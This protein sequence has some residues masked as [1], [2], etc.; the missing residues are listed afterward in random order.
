MI[1]TFVEELSS[2]ETQ[3]EETTAA[4]SRLIEELSVDSIGRWNRLI[5][6]TNWEKGEVIHRWRTQLKG[7]NL[8]NSSYSDESWSR[9]VGNVSPQHVGRLRR[10]FERFGASREQYPALYWS[11]FQAAL[12]WDDAEMW[13]EGANLDQWSVANMIIKRSVTLGAPADMKPDDRDIILS[14]LDEDASPF[15]D[16][17]AILEGSVSRI[18]PAERNQRVSGDTDLEAIPFDPQDFQEDK[19]NKKGKKSAETDHAETMTTGEALA[20]LNTVIKELPENLCEA[21]EQLKIAILSHKLSGWKEVE[22]QSVLAC[23]AVLRAVVQGQEDE[24]EKRG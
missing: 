3:L 17:Q 16:P 21:F 14:E 5:S 18:E 7:A 20:K 13:L 12:D 22:Q 8:P 4:D 23:L 24:P 11:H 2:E 9:R 15:D 10:V 6:R 19:P 1:A